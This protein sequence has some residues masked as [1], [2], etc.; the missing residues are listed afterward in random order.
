MLS[1]DRNMRSDACN[2]SGTQ[3]NVFGCPRAV[4]DSSQTLYQGILHSLSQ[5]ATG[6]NPVQKSTGR[7][8]AKSE[9]Q[10][11][12]TIP[13]PSFA[14]RRLT[15]NSFSPAEAPQNSMVDQQKLQ[16][17]EFH[18][19]KFPTPSTLSCWKIRFETQVTSCEVAPRR[20][21]SGSKG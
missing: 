11:G 21:C 5:S 12:S 10:I 6:G 17:S 8:V 4:I 1:R 9:K 20:P 13:M 14:G 18:F 19:D 7:L 3:G 16:T 2:L 15:M